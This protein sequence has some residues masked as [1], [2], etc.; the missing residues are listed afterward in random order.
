MA[1]SPDG[2]TLYA[3][4]VD[5]AFSW[6]YDAAAGSTSDKKTL[7][8]NM[9]NGG[10]STRTLLLT[11][12]VSDMLVVSRGSQGNLDYIA[13]DKSS[14][15]CQLKAFNISFVPDDGHDFTDDG[16]LLGWG[17][18]NEVGIGEHPDGGIWGVENSVDQ[19]RRDGVD[20]HQDNPGEE[21]NFFGY[22][23]GTR[24]PNQGSNFGYPICLAAWAVSSIKD[25]EGF[26]TGTQF[27]SDKS[28][29]TQCRDTTSP[30]LTFQAH[31]VCVHPTPFLWPS[32]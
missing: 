15:H 29:D 19:L 8:K 6:T 26:Q 32:H 2:K 3:S 16:I 22:L 20:I 28:N 11:K 1:I 10:H 5:E 30:R 24:N 9:G 21:L 27:A 12:Q 17:L 14:G 4:S 25:N 7:V 18:R 31:T 13:L 23:N